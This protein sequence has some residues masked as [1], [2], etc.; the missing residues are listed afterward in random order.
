MISSYLCIVEI[1]LCFE[2]YNI[3]KYKLQVWPWDS[4]AAITWDFYAAFYCGMKFYGGVKY[5]FPQKIALLSMIM[6]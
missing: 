1:V 6:T 4:A 5:G 3:L 2:S